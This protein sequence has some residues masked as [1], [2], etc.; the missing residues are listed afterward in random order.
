MMVEEY[1]APGPCIS[2]VLGGVGGPWG[3][4]SY[5]RHLPLVGR[6]ASN[7]L[8]QVCVYSGYKQLHQIAHTSVFH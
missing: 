3:Q 6:W 5:L 4:E 8:L 1:K 2:T 7:L